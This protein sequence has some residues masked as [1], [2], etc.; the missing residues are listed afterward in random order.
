MVDQTPLR[1]R[2]QRRADFAYRRLG[3]AATQKNIEAKDLANQ[4]Q[5]LG[6]FVLR[7]G[8]AATMA[9]L[10]RDKEKPPIKFLL[11]LLADWLAGREHPAP[12]KA[13][14]RPPGASDGPRSGEDLPGWVRR[15]P[16]RDYQLCT[17]ELLQLAVWLRRA[18]QVT[19][20]ENSHAS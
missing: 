18:A 6:A 11:D 7:D 17:R 4:V 3:D 10:E 20:A 12:P 9:F 13:P 14:A 15:L 1:N 19:L 8:L 5:S 16:L 2:D